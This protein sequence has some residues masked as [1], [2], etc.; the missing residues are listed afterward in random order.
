MNKTLRRTLL[1]VGLGVVL[2]AAGAL[3]FGVAEIEAS[4]RTMHLRGLWIAL[5]MSSLAY[6]FR[7]LKWELSLRWLQVRRAPLDQPLGLRASAAIFL[8]GLSMS[9][10]P[11]KLGEVV[12]SSLLKSNHGVPFTKTAPFV[13]ADRAAD[14]IA[15][16][17]FCLLGLGTIAGIAGYVW[18]AALLVSVGVLVLGNRSLSKKLTATLS[19]IPRLSRFSDRIE[20]LLQ[21]ARV[22]LHPR[23]LAILSVLSLF[24]WGLEC[25]GY[26]FILNSFPQIDIDLRT[27]VLLW[28]STTL[29][30]AI[31]FLPGGL[32]ATEGSLGVLATRLVP[33]LGTH[34]AIASTFV[35]RAATLWFGELVGAIALWRCVARAPSTAPTTAGDPDIDQG[36]GG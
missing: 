19:T 36:A 25:A 35:I 9:V 8:A 29:I 10:T 34:A 21:S 32:G 20:G 5:A 2:Y 16:V 15:L 26:M 1:G 12:R 13:V 14:V 11:G 30:G 4:L 28:S 23:R 18:A 3:W 6:M 22:L 33:G 31:S 17:C 24:A 27:C 7:F